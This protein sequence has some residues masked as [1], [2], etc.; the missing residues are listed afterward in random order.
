MKTY[1]VGGAIRD[2]LLGLPVK[3]LDYLVVGATPEEMIAKGF[4]P[5]GQDFPVFLHPDTCAEYALART[6][7]KTAPGYKGFI[8]HA[9]EHVTLEEDLARRDLTINAMARE[10]DSN[11]VVVG[12]LIDPFGGQK[13]LQD[14]L[15]RHVGDAFVEDPVR[16]LR[17]ARFAARFPSFGVAPNTLKL[18]KEIGQSG[19]LD[20]LVKER[21]WQEFSKGL[22]SEKPSRMLDVLDAIEV[23]EKFFPSDLLLKS[24]RKFFDYIDQSKSLNFNLQQRCAVL[25]CGL[26]AEII[27]AWSAKWGIPS[28]C[29]DYALL[30]HELHQK[31]E[32][33]LSKAEGVLQILD[34]VDVWRKPDRFNELI[35]VIKLI[36]DSAELLMKG[37]I[38]A[39]KVN[40][41]DIAASVAQQ[42]SGSGELIKLA[43]DK[44][45]QD[46]IK[47]VLA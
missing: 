4:R 14:K 9:D 19:E 29:R 39:K 12:S 21:V 42:G 22:L 27:N 6:E 38:A 10:I 18:L 15:F 25:L 16:L 44:A 45:R 11:G 40:V 34:R 2:E 32:L 1:V 36:G 7:R 5:V 46:A 41:S 33:G 26:D 30:G 37:Y 8:F 13:D 43:I 24:N 35:D 23:F 17:V 47:G 28:D 20:A 31:I 3:D